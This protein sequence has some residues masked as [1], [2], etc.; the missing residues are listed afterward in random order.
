MWMDQEKDYYVQ[1]NLTTVSMFLLLLTVHV[2][3]LTVYISFLTHQ[4]MT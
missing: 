1:T 4:E 2:L 3:R